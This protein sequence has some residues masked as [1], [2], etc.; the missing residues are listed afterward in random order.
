M[1]DLL[2]EV[3]RIKTER[4]AHSPPDFLPPPTEPVGP[5]P[6]PVPPAI[7]IGHMVGDFGGSRREGEG[8]GVLGGGVGGGDDGRGK[9]PLAAQGAG[10]GLQGKGFDRLRLAQNRN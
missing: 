10:A 4:L 1:G 3:V 2:G 7:P 6:Y 5:R 8:G 9:A